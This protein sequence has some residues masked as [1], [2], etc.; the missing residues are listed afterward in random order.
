MRTMILVFSMVAASGVVL[1]GCGRGPD[2]RSPGSP[3]GGDGGAANDGTRND[4]GPGL[5]ADSSTLPQTCGNGV[6][7]GTEECD[8][9]EGTRANVF[10][11]GQ[12]TCDALV[13]GTSG[14]VWCNANCRIDTS[15]CESG[16]GGAG[17]GGYGGYGG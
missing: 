17:Y 11:A 9:R 15:Y 14:E 12:E 7:E 4:G 10:P 16:D 3:Y 6:I 1:A 5:G 2:G 8:W 13:A